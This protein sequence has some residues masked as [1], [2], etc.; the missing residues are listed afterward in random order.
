VLP[1]FKDGVHWV[2]LVGISDE[3]LIPQ[4]IAQSLRLP[5]GANEPFIEVL[6]IYLKPKESLIVFDN[7]EHLIRACA[8]YI[9][10]LLASCPKL[11]ILATSI[12]GLGLFNETIWQVPSLPVPERKHSLSP[13]ELQKYASIELFAERAKAVKSDFRITDQV[14]KSVAQICQRLDGIPL[15]I[16]LAAARTKVLSV[17]E[18]ASRLDDRFSLLTAGSRTAI[19]RHQT[20]RAT[21]DWSHDL[22]TETEKMLFRRLAVFAGGFT[23]QAAET[24]C[25]FGGLTREDILALLGRLVDKSLVFVEST[26][27]GEETRYHLLETIR[28]YALEKLTEIGEA[29]DIRNQH[30][31]FYVALAEK[32]EPENFGAKAGVWFKRL[33]KELDNIRLAMEWA[34]T[35][36]QAVAALRI[37]GSLVY[38]WFAHGHVASEW[39]DRVQ[40][41]L[42][43]PEGM[44]PTRA[45][46]KAFNGFGWMYWADISPTD[47]R[48]QFEEALR[49]GKELGDSSIIA[50]AL[51]NL[52]LLENIEGNFQE[53]RSFLEQSLVVCN[54][55]GIEGKNERAW[56]MN[57]LGDLALNQ[58]DTIRAKVY[59]E[60]TAAL[61]RETGNINFL[62][63]TTRRLAHLAWQAGDFLKAIQ[64]CTESLLM[65]Q[66]VNDPRGMIASLAGFV[67][68]AVAQGKFGRAAVLKAAIDAQIA[69]TGIHLLYIDKKEYERNILLLSE[70][71]IGKNTDRFQAKGQ[72]MTLEEA[73][74]FALEG[75]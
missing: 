6:K 43:R 27:V 13:Q 37:A 3:N 32:T 5:E 38:Y 66:E 62:A 52:G 42:D 59:F 56:T 31:E 28:Q 4:E 49:I 72:S 36:G 30:L 51:R 68:I 50:L 24:V 67:A 35:S 16:E 64:L 29:L 17:D 71:L 54:D 41:A 7:C 26:S 12:E 21:I 63:Y 23:L 53:A 65:N 55:M 25:A 58:G 39:N 44:E 9:E 1:K 10:Q 33:D 11:K 61:Q 20:L 47:R 2:D 48:P 22:L 34:T 69:S 46:A 19:P 14:A 15:A 45:R 70:Q 60:D 57:F 8:Q 75:S 40:Q 74:A 18:I 73:I